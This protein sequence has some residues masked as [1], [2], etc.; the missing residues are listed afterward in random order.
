MKHAVELAEAIKSNY[1][2]SP[3]EF[4]SDISQ[5]LVLFAD[6]RVTYINWFISN[7]KDKNKVSEVKWSNVKKKKRRGKKRSKFKGH[8]EIV[9]L[10]GEFKNFNGNYRYALSVLSDFEN[11]LKE[12]GKYDEIIVLSKPLNVDANSIL[13]GAADDKNDIKNNKATFSI[14]IIKKVP[15]NV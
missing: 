6:I 5:D 7:D 15:L 4:L 13:K 9:R 12:S 8:Y 1:N 14:K 3:K 11:L 10:N 2:H